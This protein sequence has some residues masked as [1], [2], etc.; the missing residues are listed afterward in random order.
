M[1][2]LLLILI[3][4]THAFAKDEICLDGHVSGNLQQLAHA[5][6]K[7]GE[8][9]CHKTND[10][11][12]DVAT[13]CLGGGG[14]AVVGAVKGFAELLRL[15]VV[16]APSYMWES[17]SSGIKKLM[18]GDLNPADMAS[19]IANVNIGSQSELWNKAKVYWESFKKFTVELKNNLVSKIQGFP[20][21]PLK[22]Q[23]E[24]I[25]RGVSEVFLLVVSP[26]KF[27][28][29]A[30][31]GINTAKA[32]QKFIAE[33]SSIQ[34][35]SKMSLAGRLNAATE[36]LKDGKRAATELM[37]LNKS[38]LVEIELPNGEKI[39][40]YDQKI[41]GKDGKTHT[42]SREVPLDA[43]TKTIDANSAIG[44]QIMSEAVKAKA[45]KGSLVFIDVNYLGKV[46]YF[47]GGTQTGDQYLTSVAESLRKTLRPGDMIFKNGGDELVVVLGTRDRQAVKEISQRMMNEVD[48]NPQIK[49]L[50]KRE[51]TSIT[52]A[53]KEVNTAK[54]IKDLP[55]GV[56]KALTP[57]EKKIALS[58]FSKFQVA[59]KADLKAQMMG[60]A[61]Y[62]G[63]IS[64]GSS[65]V[66]PNETITNVLARAEQQAAQVK[67]RYKA[68]YGHDISKYNIEAPLIS[69]PRN[70]PPVALDP[71]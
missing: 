66:K 12:L 68:R 65:L 32:M 5:A 48:K 24:I 19:S 33:T 37:R 2:K 11:I 62:R 60:Q 70:G 67:A 6:A 57:A 50:F 54:S 49:Q 47:K 13:G 53:Y 39:L 59:K 23:S 30:K 38:K 9:H 21:L 14:K 16:E 40:R 61:T 27:L 41:V 44:K 31:W 8:V 35:L 58:N 15:L 20:C 1:I 55:A 34:G 29:G 17:A 56:I 45:G 10:N 4:S 22:K 3:L 28:Q 25:C 51:V 18:S 42:V 36:A 43:K 7:A 46:N 69:G 26:A 71:I 52:Q 63:S 64:V